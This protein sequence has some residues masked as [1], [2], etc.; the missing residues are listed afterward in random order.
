MQVI[1]IIYLLQLLLLITKNWDG[2]ATQHSFPIFISYCSP[3]V[4]GGVWDFSQAN[5]F[6]FN[7]RLNDLEWNICIHIIIAKE[8]AETLWC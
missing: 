1:S 2:L 4:G 6:I 7:L 5:I 3:F 8:S